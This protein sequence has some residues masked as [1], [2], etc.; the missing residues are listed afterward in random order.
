MNVLELNNVQKS[1]AQTTPG[2][3]ERIQV[4]KNINLKVAEGE[5]VAI[6]GPSGSGKTTLLSLITGLDRPDTGQIL[7]NGKNITE[8]SENELTLFRAKNVGIV[9]QQYH[10]LNYLNAFENTALPLELLEELKYSEIERRSQEALEAVGLKDRTHHF[11]YQLSGGENQ[12]VAI[13]RALITSPKLL[14]ADE[15]SG[16][17]DEKTGLVVMNYL[18]ELVKKTNTTLLLVT[19]NEEL[20]RR[21]GR[22][23]RLQE[24]HATE[25]DQALHI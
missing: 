2:A 14:I 13:A 12:R 24:G 10:L 5:S 17:L 23:V 22:T 3:Q 20:A 21:C 4:L 8:L 25:N 6:L 15:P 11:P 1:F 18:F 9:F 16:S 19:H 7:F